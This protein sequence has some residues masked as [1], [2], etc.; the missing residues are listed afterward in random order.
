M[1]N[2]TVLEPPR[3]T[4]IAADP[5]TDRVVEAVR[6]WHDDVRHEGTF[7]FCTERPCLDALDA[8]P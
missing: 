8:L 2:P 3:R 1:S 4:E 7:E 6:R 5:A